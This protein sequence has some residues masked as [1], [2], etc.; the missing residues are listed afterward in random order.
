MNTLN[1]PGISSSAKLGHGQASITATATNTATATVTVTKQSGRAKLDA[2]LL[3]YVESRNKRRRT[4]ISTKFRVKSSRTLSDKGVTKQGANVAVIPADNSADKPSKGTKSKRIQRTQVA[5]QAQILREA[6]HERLVQLSEHSRLAR[7]PRLA[8]LAPRKVSVCPTNRS[9]ASIEMNV[10]SGKRESSAVSTGS[11]DD[12]ANDRGNGSGS[13]DRTNDQPPRAQ[14]AKVVSVAT[15][16]IKRSL[17]PQVDKQS[18]ETHRI[19][20]TDLCVSMISK[21]LVSDIVSVFGSLGVEKMAVDSL[22]QHLC[23]DSSKP[24]STYQGKPIGARQLNRVITKELGIHSYDIR[25]GVNSGTNGGT[26]GSANGGAKGS[27]IV[28]GLHR[29][30]F[31][32]LQVLLN[33]GHCTP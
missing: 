23:A 12:R 9:V 17:T 13:V 30:V 33:A 11:D 1:T 18:V 16:V 28:K 27:K 31:E 4:K 10:P 24:W 6:R 22:L 29:R 14:R 5:Q 32:L 15:P 21:S 20:G 26:N 25:V 8:R 7:S 3:K 2:P 19:V